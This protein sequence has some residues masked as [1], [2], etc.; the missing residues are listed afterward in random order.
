MMQVLDGLESVADKVDG[1]ENA[2]RTD[3]IPGTETVPQPEDSNDP[4]SWCRF[5]LPV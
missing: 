1:L 3:N 4:G 2:P 5:R